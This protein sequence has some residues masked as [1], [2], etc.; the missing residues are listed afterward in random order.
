M[1][2]KYILAIDQGTTSSRAIAF[3]QDG[4][5]YA[6]SQ[7]EISQIFPQPGW[8]EQD[9]IEIWNSVQ[10][11]I[12]G[13]LIEG[14]IHPEEIKAIGITNQRETTVLWDKVTGE[15]VYH[16]IVWQSK[17]SSKVADHWKAQEHEALVKAKTGL[18]IDSY[19]SATKIQWL[20]EQKPEI[21]GRAQKGELLFGTIDTWLLWNLTGGKVHKTDM[22][23]ASRTMLF[24]IH[25]LTWDQELLDLFELPASLLPE[26]ASNAEI[27]GYTDASDYLFSGQTIPIAG[28]A[29]DQQAALIG[30]GA[31]KTGMI[32][33]T[34]GTGAFILMNT[35]NKPIVSENG[36]ITTIAYQMNGEVTYALEGSIF[37][38]GSA[39]QWLRDGLELIENAA[40][41]KNYCEAV[42][43]SDNLYVVPAFTGLGAPYWDQEAR[44]A[45]FGITR[46]TN[47]AHFIRATVESLA[48]QTADVVKTMVHDANVPVT[49]LKADGGASKNDFLMQ[50]QADI[51]QTKVK[52]P[53]FLETTALGAAFL[54]GLTTGFWQS[55]DEIKT[56]YMNAETFEPQMPSATSENLYQG[57]QEAVEATMKFKHRPINN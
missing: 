25:D 20:F 27:F 8:V 53:A 39:I 28:I 36:L 41:T 6:S 44:G 50:F 2:K 49:L 4:H 32:K 33:N 13:V 52:R 48:Y 29:G 18:P 34:Y 47:K 12:A 9:P 19:F 23:N 10:N 56:V 42:V 35:G 5:A 15:P 3:T 11:V 22:T 43:D 14:K 31:L 46:G 17:Q 55:F 37:V 7:R 26:V 54:A 24:N 38:A 57:W 1:E 30:Q 51:L 40:E 45:I 21:K 16:A